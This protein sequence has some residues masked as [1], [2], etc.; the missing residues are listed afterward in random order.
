MIGK[1]IEKEGEQR[2]QQGGQYRRKAVEP[3][4]S[5]GGASERE[6]ARRKCIPRLT[7]GVH[8]E[9]EQIIDQVSSCHP[10]LRVFL[11]LDRVKHASLVDDT[12]HVEDLAGYGS[13]CRR[14]LMD[15]RRTV[16]V[17]LVAVDGE[18]SGVVRVGP[19]PDNNDQAADEHADELVDNR[20]SWQD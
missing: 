10:R 20:E 9:E 7:C 3:R 16:V 12:Q 2:V 17:R 18:V 11:V 19:V 1:R 8:G 14:I 15:M 6:A 4:W 5:G 13:A